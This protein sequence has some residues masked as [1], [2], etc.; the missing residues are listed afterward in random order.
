MRRERVTF[1]TFRCKRFMSHQDR[2][3]RMVCV[4]MRELF[5]FEKKGSVL[6]ATDIGIKFMTNL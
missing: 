6:T 2:R 1:E 5:A 3:M 4:V